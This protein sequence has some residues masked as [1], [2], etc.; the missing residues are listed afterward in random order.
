MSCKFS[1]AKEK[2]RK[3]RKSGIGRTLN[4][5][6]GC[7]LQ[8]G[9]IGVY[10][11]L[12]QLAGVWGQLGY[13]TRPFR[14]LTPLQYQECNCLKSSREDRTPQKI[15]RS[16]DQSTHVCGRFRQLDRAEKHV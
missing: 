16:F 6:L 5:P 8:P 3:S 1:E 15:Y 4:V 7:L 9:S 11:R 14:I 2:E 12:G 13:E 10:F